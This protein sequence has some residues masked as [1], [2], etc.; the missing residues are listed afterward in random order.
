MHP[1]EEL[2]N[3]LMGGKRRA[4]VP[5][6]NV[7]T[8]SNNTRKFNENPPTEADLRAGD[9]AYVAAEISFIA[10]NRFEG[11][12]FAAIQ[13]ALKGYQKKLAETQEALHDLPETHA[14]REE[15]FAAYEAQHATDTL[16]PK[17]KRGTFQVVMYLDECLDIR[18]ESTCRVLPDES[19]VIPEIKTIV[20]A[21][22]VTEAAVP[23]INI[24]IGIGLLNIATQ[25]QVQELVRVVSEKEALEYQIRLLTSRLEIVTA[26]AQGRT[27]TAQ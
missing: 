10:A 20:A 12:T 19:Y 24:Q 6:P 17:A 8:A 15:G 14:D 13:T 3:G 7:V 25:G 1:L 16:C 9:A 26:M 5:A 22:D 18:V 4:E 23:E 2:L 27:A 21:V 11:D